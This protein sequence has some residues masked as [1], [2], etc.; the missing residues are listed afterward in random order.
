MAHLGARLPQEWTSSFILDMRMVS[1]RLVI[2][3]LLNVQNGTLCT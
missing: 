2:D 1:Y 3:D